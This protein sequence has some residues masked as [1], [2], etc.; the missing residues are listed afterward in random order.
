MP[1]DG[2]NR[3][4]NAA[5]LLWIAEAVGVDEAAVAA[6]IEAAKS[7]GDY[8][9]ACGAQVRSLGIR[10]RVYVSLTGRNVHAR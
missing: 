7:A 3:L 4:S 2:D 5:S 10:F 9:R 1:V 8:R 6:T